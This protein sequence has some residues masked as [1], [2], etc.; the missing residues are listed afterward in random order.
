[1]TKVN[2]FELPNPLLTAHSCTC[3]SVDSGLKILF[4][5]LVDSLIPASLATSG[6]G[7]YEDGLFN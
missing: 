6:F 2:L 7:V 1:M 4:G 5:S 3:C